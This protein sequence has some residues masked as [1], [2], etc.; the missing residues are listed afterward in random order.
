[1]PSGQE[2]AK[3]LG[4]EPLAAKALRLKEL[5]AAARNRLLKATPLWYYILC[6]AERE[7]GDHLGPLGGRIV[8]DVILRL[9][10]SD[11]GSY[12]H[13]KSW[14]PTLVEGKDDFTMTDLIEV[15]HGWE[16]RQPA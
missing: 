10:G 7:G 9:L 12:V 8:A 15:A 2:V 6:E 11:P 4:L 13:D 5:P 14:R 16:G 1:M 3:H